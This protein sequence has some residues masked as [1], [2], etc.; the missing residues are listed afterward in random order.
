[1]RVL[2]VGSTVGEAGTLE[3]EEGTDEYQ[4]SEADNSTEGRRQ[5]DA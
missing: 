4:A 5:N 2:A 1:V 3:E